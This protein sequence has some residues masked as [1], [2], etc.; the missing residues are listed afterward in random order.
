MIMNATLETAKIKS[1]HISQIASGDTIEH[2]GKLTTVC[3]NNIKRGGFCGDT[4][5]GDS[6]RSGTI[7]VKKVVGWIGKTGEVFPIR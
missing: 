4:L 5:F 3:A 6:Y 2:N 7:L 1:V